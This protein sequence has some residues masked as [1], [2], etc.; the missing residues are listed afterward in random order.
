MA[1][2][3]IGLIIWISAHFVKR[4]APTYRQ[5]LQDKMGDASKGVFALAMVLSIVLMVIGYKNADSTYYWGRS[6]MTTGLNN[7]LMLLAV[8]LFGLGSS[9]S[10]F[11]SKLRHPMLLGVVVW[12]VS[13]I[14]VNGDSASFLLFGG[15]GAWALVHIFAI[16]RT[17]P[18]YQPYDGGSQ[19]GDVRLLIISVVVFTVISMIHWWLGYNPFGA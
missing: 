5:T 10:R 1:F 2:I 15:L 11:R 9:K 13:H 8:G 14:L 18:D 4:L 6:G 3:A 17:E 19:A 7:L 16:N 12:A